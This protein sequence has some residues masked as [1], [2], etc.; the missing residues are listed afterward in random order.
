MSRA[1]RKALISL[2]LWDIGLSVLPYFGFR[3]AGLN[4]TASLLGGTGVASLRLL[5]VLVRHRRLDGLAAFM[6]GILLLGLLGLVTT[7]DV[8]VLAAKDSITTI[9]V[10]GTFIVTALVG[11]PVMYLISKKFRALDAESERRWDLLWSTEP[12]FRRIYVLGSTVWGV[13]L[14][15]EAVARI[16]AVMVLPVDVVVA[17]S[18]P[19]LL[20]VIALL[21]AWTIWMRRRPTHRVWTERVR[22]LA[23]ES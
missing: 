3:L 12:K 13:G 11:R 16:V 17:L 23:M 1:A 8:R 14:L 22:N 21:T 20:A 7:G 5:Y 2:L 4:E 19:V 15:A 18:A 9:F 10:G 6:I